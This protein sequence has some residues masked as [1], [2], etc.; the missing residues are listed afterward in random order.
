MRTNDA[1][2]KKRNFCTFFRNGWREKRAFLIHLLRD[3]DFSQFPSCCVVPLLAGAPGVP[4]SG[5]LYPTRSDLSSSNKRTGWAFF[6]TRKKLDAFLSFERLCVSSLVSDVTCKSPLV[7]V[8]RLGFHCLFRSTRRRWK[9]SSWQQQKDPLIGNAAFF[10]G[11]LKTAT[12]KVAHLSNRAQR[13]RRKVF[14][15]PSQEPMMRLLTWKPGHHKKNQSVL[16]EKALV[17]VFF[18]WQIGKHAMPRTRT[19]DYLANKKG[20]N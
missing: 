19:Q 8:F 5:D 11:H 15:S 2:K 18:H 4:F 14:F 1:V 7:F 17:F 10:P 13:R 12:P 6:C 9:K 16:C 20:L 3:L